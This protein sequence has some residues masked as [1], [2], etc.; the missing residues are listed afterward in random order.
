M[1]IHEDVRTLTEGTELSIDTDIETVSADHFEEI[2]EFLTGTRNCWIGAI[3]YNDEGE[4]LLIKHAGEPGWT[5]PGGMVES[6]EALEP[7][8]KREIREETGV[9]VTVEEPFY[10]REGKYQHNT[11]T[12]S[13]YSVLFI[14]KADD[15]SIGDELGLAD[16]PISDAQWFEEIPNQIHDLAS[17]DRLQQAMHEIDRRI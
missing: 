5:Q 1:D 13:W 14:A 3:V 16:E 6:G 4:I 8:L 7:A 15:P 9:D 17:Q 10:I 12:I 2:Q 11:N